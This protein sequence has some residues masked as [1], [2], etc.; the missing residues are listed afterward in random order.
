MREFKT[1]ATRDDDTAKPDY[2]GFLSPLVIRRY[3]EYMTK[4]RV[5]ADGKLRDSDNWQKGIPL[6]AYMKSLWRHVVDLWTM[7]RASSSN[8]SVAEFEHL[9]EEALCAIIFNASGYLHEMEKLKA[10]TIVAPPKTQ[11]PQAGDRPLFSD[12]IRPA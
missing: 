10:S 9:A 12:Y 4:H 3:G 7:H 6:T 11:E 8:E 1:G 2:E 5:Q